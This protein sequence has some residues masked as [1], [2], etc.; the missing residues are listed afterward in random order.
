MHKY[1]SKQLED[2]VRARLAR[3]FVL[4]GSSSSRPLG[5]YALPNASIDLS[6]CVMVNT[7]EQEARDF[8]AHYNFVTLPEDRS[9]LYLP[10]SALD[11]LFSAE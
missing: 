3:A 5:F 8:Y 7:R 2:G 11:E 10:M 1:F 6:W 4:V 9:S